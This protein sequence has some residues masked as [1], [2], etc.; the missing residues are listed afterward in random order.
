MALKN[1]PREGGS[2]VGVTLPQV[3]QL[4]PQVAVAGNQRVGI[5]KLLAE[6]G[7]LLVILCENIRVHAEF[8]NC[9]P[10][11]VLMT[12][13]LAYQQGDHCHGD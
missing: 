13:V 6:V 10:Q 3:R 5:H 7:V 2:L 11:L 1:F 12:P 4:N 9:G 8:T